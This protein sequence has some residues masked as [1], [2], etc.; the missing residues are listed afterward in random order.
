MSWWEKLCNDQC[1]LKNERCFHNTDYVLTYK[2]NTESQYDHSDK[3]NNLISSISSTTSN[4]ENK[5]SYN[6]DF[7]ITDQSS[8]QNDENVSTIC[9]GNT[10][11]EVNLH[12]QD[13]YY[14]LHQDDRMS[15][16]TNPIFN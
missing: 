5:E 14:L 2:D 15:G 8:F 12:P 9:H 6:I 10:Y 3:Q 16:N 4:A 7:D 11:G 1:I 13:S